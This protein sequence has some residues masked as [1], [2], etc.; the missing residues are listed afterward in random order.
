MRPPTAVD[1]VARAAPAVVDLGTGSGA[2]RAADPEGAAE[3]P[4]DRHRRR[5]GHAR[6]GDA[7]AARPHP[8]DRG[9]LRAHS[10]SRAATWSR[11]RSRCITSRPAA[12][13]PR[14]TSAASRRCAPAAC[15]SA[16]TASSRRARA[17]QKRHREAWLSHLQRT[18]T[19]QEGGELPEDV[20]EGRRLLHARSRDRVAE[21]RGLRGG[22]DVAPRQLRGAG[23]P[24]VA[25]P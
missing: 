20:G 12:A 10:H 9:Q 23:G 11:R 7:A 6:H 2:A 14:S 16:P 22:S 24:E 13:R 4:A 1:V 5:S 15:S 19:R 8:D 25:R 17:V 18:Y 3:G 21:G